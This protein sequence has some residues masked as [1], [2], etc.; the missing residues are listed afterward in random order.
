MQP[1][2]EKAKADYDFEYIKPPTKDAQ[3]ERILELAKCFEERT[4]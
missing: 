2:K 3:M 1:D 4:V